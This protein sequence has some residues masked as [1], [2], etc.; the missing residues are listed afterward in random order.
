MLKLMTKYK[1]RNFI[2]SSSATLYAGGESF[3]ETSA[4]S[5]IN[6]YAETKMIVEMIMKDVAAVNKDCCF[7]ALRY[8]NPAGCHKSGLIGDAPT[9]P[10]NLFPIVE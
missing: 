4:V 2:F 1:C 6:V 7:F 3:D 5:P 8:F 10:N 9:Y